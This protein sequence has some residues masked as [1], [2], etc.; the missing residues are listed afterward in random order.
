MNDLRPLAPNDYEVVLYHE[1]KYIDSGY[2]ILLTLTLFCSPIL[3]AYNAF[4]IVPFQC[5][6]DLDL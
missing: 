6:T 1:E 4:S 5:P 2:M 3:S